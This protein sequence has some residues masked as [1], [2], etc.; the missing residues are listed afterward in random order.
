MDFEGDA[1]SSAVLVVAGIPL[2]LL[3]VLNKFSISE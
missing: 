2:F 1:D 3:L